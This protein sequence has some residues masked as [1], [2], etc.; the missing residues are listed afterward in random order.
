MFTVTNPIIISG[1]TQLLNEMSADVDKFD[2]I[3]REHYESCDI[4]EVRLIISCMM[5]LLYFWKEEY[6]ETQKEQPEE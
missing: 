5:S 1:I 6:E 3:V 2:D 4:H